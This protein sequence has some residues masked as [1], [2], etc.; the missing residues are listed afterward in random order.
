MA[1]AAGARPLRAEVADRPAQDGLRRAYR[2]LVARSV[3][4]MGGVAAHAR[5]PC[6]L[7]VRASRAGA[8]GVEGAPRGEPQLAISVVDRADAAGMAREVGVTPRP[9]KILYV[10]AG[11]RSGGGEAELARLATATPGVADEI[12]SEEH[13]SELQSL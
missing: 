5:A 8:A 12:R 11:L 9:G 7:R 6:R 2:C 4:R 13:T 1:A 10:T 3:A